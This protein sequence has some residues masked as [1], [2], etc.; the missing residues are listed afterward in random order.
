VIFCFSGFYVS[1]KFCHFA[2]P[3][4]KFQINPA[5]VINFL[6]FGLISKKNTLMPLIHYK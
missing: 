5:W 2:F 4:L 1:N 6:N 3:A